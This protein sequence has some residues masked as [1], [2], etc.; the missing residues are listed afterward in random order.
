MANK[1]KDTNSSQFFLTY[2]AVAHLDRKHTIFGRV[3]QGMDVLD[4]L[5]AVRTGDKDKPIE[6]CVLDDIVVFIDP[7]AEYAKQ[8]SEADN[9]ALQSEKV[10]MQ[11]GAEDDH[12]TWTGKKIGA[13]GRVEEASAGQQVGRYLSATPAVQPVADEVIGDWDEPEARPAKKMKSK[14]GGFG[15]FDSW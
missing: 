7:F 4:R 2:R 10:A 9:A 13:D 14:P 15:N 1:G 3:V 11:G 6:T 12:T 8:R 5:E